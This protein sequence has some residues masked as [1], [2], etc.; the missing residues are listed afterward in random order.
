MTA[1]PLILMAGLGVFVVY[2]LYTAERDRTGAIRALAVRLGMHYLGNAL[3]KS[4][5]LDGTPFDHPSKVWNMVDG[6]PR[7]TRIM[8][9]DC[10]VGAGRHSWRRTV[11]AVESEH[12]VLEHL[13][14][15]PDMRI[16]RA[17]RWQI[18]YRPKARFNIRI[19]GLTPVNELEANLNAIVA[20]SPKTK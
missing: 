5:R 17:G 12:N 8:A 11:I 13:P 1:I 14:S 6:E 20:D 3:P 9:F 2:R 18:L 19:A 4:L 10:R 15:N 7:G 16:D